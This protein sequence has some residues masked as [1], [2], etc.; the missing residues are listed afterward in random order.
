MKKNY[1]INPAF[2]VSCICLFSIALWGC[3]KEQQANDVKVTETE[4]VTTSKAEKESQKASPPAELTGE[5]GGVPIH[6]TYSQPAVRN[7]EIWGQL[8]PY[9]EVWRTGANEANI[10]R[11]E[12]DVWIEGQ[13]LGAGTYTLFT[14]PDEKQWT[15]I[16]NKETEDQWGAYNYQPE[17]DALRVTVTPQRQDKITERL[18]FSID[19]TNKLIFQWEKLRFDLTLEEAR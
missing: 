14:L 11:F 8:V 18:T 6:L 17:S 19:T 5:V 16:F 1:V 4:T 3:Q 10:I 15:V 9:G 12:K 13:K 2:I 7:R